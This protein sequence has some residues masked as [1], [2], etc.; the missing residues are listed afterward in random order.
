MF[1]NIIEINFVVFSI[2]QISA[3][4]QSQRSAVTEGLTAGCTGKTHPHGF[5]YF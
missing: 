4:D 1:L 2:D 3:D 5:T